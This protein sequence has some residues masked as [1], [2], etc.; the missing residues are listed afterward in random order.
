MTEE[1]R[2]SAS[3][4]FTGRIGRADLIRVLADGGLDLQRDLAVRLGFSVRQ[5][6]ARPVAERVPGSTGKV[7][8]VEPP[9]VVRPTQSETEFRPVPTSFW[10]PVSLAIRG[11]LPPLERKRVAGGIGRQS[12]RVCPAGLEFEPLAPPAVLRTRLRCLSA[13]QAERKKPDL[14]KVIRQISRG[15]MPRTI[16]RLKRRSWGREFHIIA[17][18]AD[19]LMPYRD[20]QRAVIA[21]LQ[22]LLPDSVLTLSQLRHRASWPEILQP[23]D[24]YCDPVRPGPDATVLALTDLGSLGWQGRRDD[25]LGIGDELERARCRLFALVPCR[26]DAVPVGLQRQW[27]LIAWEHLASDSGA[28]TD[29]ELTRLLALL[30]QAV[31]IEP[32]L[33]RAVRRLLPGGKTDAGLEALFWRDSSIISGHVEAATMSPAAVAALRD[34]LRNEPDELRRHVLDLI[35]SCHAPQYDGIWWTDIVNLGEDAERL[36]LKDEY[37]AAHGWFHD[38]LDS[39]D[40]DGGDEAV[41]EFARRADSLLQ[42]EAIEFDPALDELST[43]IAIGGDAGQR[44]AG[45]DPR[46]GVKAGERSIHIRPAGERWAFTTARTDQ[47]GEGCL[48]TVTS[49]VAEIRIDHLREPAG[50]GR[51]LTVDTPTED[52]WRNFWADGT[53]PDWATA[54]GLDEFGLWADLGVLVARSRDEATAA[55]A[56]LLDPVTVDGQVWIDALARQLSVEEEDLRR[57]CHVWGFEH[58]Q[59][60]ARS[61][62]VSRRDALTL[63]RQIR[64]LDG[65]E[66]ETVTA[67][68]QMRWVPAGTFWMGSAEDEAGRFENEG[69]RHEVRISRGFWMFDAPVTQEFW[70]AVMGENPSRFQTPDRPVEQVSWEDCQRFFER[71]RD[72]VPGLEIDLPTEAEWEFAC[73]GGANTAPYDGA[74]EILGINNAP[75]LDPVGWYGGNSGIDFELEDGDDASGWSE[76]QYE[77]DRAGTHPVR[78]KQPNALG[79][80]DMLG[81]VLEWCRDAAFRDYSDEAVRYIL[82]EGDA[83]AYR[84]VRG[85]SWRNFARLVRAAYRGAYSPGYRHN[86]IGFRPRVRGCEPSR[87]AEQQAQGRSRERAVSRRSPSAEQGAD[88]ERASDERPT[89]IPGSAT[90]NQTAPPTAAPAAAQSSRLAPRDEPDAPLHGDRFIDAI[91]MVGLDVLPMPD[92]ADDWGLDEFGLW[93]EF[94]IS[95]DME[96]SEATMPIASADFPIADAVFR[97]RQRLRLIPPGTFLMGSSETEEVEADEAPQHN[98]TISQAFWL[99]DSP[100]TQV[101]WSILARDQ[102]SKFKGEDRPVERVS[103]DDCRQFSRLLSERLDGVEVGLPTEAEWEYACRAGSTDTRY[104]ELKDV[105]WY[106][107]SSG[108][109]TKPVRRKQPNAWGLFDTLGNVWEW[110]RDA[111]YRD[112]REEPVEDPIHDGDASALR[113]VRGGSWYNV[114]RAVRA[115]YRRARTPGHRDH[116]IGFRPRVREHKLQQAVEQALAGGPPAG[117]EGR[118]SVERRSPIA[119]PGGDSGTASVA[120]AAWINLVDA[121]SD[122]T[123]VP[124][125]P[126]VRI[127]TDVEE[128]TLRKITKPAWASAMGRDRFGLW[129]EIEVGFGPTV[130]PQIDRDGLRTSFTPRRKP[131][132]VTQRLRWI[133]PGQFQFGSP[134]DEP[135][136][137][138]KYEF[139]PRTEPIR[140]GFWLFDTPV[141]QEL[142]E[143]VMQVESPAYFKSRT[144]PVEQVSWDDCQEFEKK[145]AALFAER[146]F[147]LGAELPSEIEWE[148]A[149]RAG[150]TQATYGGAIEY[151][152]DGNAPALDPLAWYS[153]NCGV[154]FDLD[155]GIEVNWLSDKQYEFAAGGTRPVRM[156]RSNAWG[157]YDML[158]NVWE[159]CADVFAKP[160]QEPGDVEDAASARRVVRG[161]SWP[162]DARRVRAAY[163]DANSPGDRYND[164]GFRPRVR[165]LQQ[166][167]PAG[168]SGMVE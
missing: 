49:S 18:I 12:P 121:D 111:A 93:A 125:G 77:F 166:A 27:G 94:E 134:Q 15:E 157:L 61:W 140:E 149:C 148:Y 43:K 114:A 132:V 99:F 100:C 128:L 7:Q 109:K 112:Y 102:P 1:R 38:I 24:S 89:A 40:V 108:N 120:R 167:Q 158:G 63:L 88:S 58:I 81:N 65:S 54:W 91:A 36:V 83:S 122:S 92:W 127:V 147:G 101:L 110:C 84:V 33:L 139:E 20:D 145:F 73:R 156:K 131:G 116:N 97:H 66:V 85:G 64:K 78:R 5:P 28:E 135:G 152:G 75:A 76:K 16:P 42:S 103:W 17:D 138:D 151:L 133:P 25:W 124:Q 80:F 2:Q 31:R 98:V 165:E 154:D 79:L 74:F 6:V 22:K 10:Q 3:P 69:P 142:W 95:R 46:R 30:S 70:E 60:T 130:D 11:A 107:K 161:G 129:C 56:E 118:V 164:I 55:E 51:P 8:H 96:I 117:S 115:A 82:F 47:P 141:T 57:T 45:S 35:W 39:I 4:I 29:R 50:R 41:V 123:P 86:F 126:A 14:K 44:R 62:S 146:G 153:G 105:A 34:A 119:E 13:G 19:H 9:T 113:V 71:L 37:E 137:H 26:L 53:P 162:A 52:K 32:R 67:T 23:T 104:G 144:R 155:N 143:A 150:T 68:Q 160:D 59:K 48:A 106:S 163:R 90:A 159:W 72:L 136:R 87:V 21:A 168:A